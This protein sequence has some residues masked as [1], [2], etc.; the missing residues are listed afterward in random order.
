MILVLTVGLD[1]GHRASI[2][3]FSERIVHVETIRAEPVVYSLLDLHLLFAVSAH[4][5]QHNRFLDATGGHV[6]RLAIL[7]LRRLFLLALFA[8][9]A[10]FEVVVAA[11]GARPAAVWE[12]VC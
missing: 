11:L 9:C 10:A 7:V 2:T 1:L 12:L 6:L 4:L 5:C 8:A 3:D